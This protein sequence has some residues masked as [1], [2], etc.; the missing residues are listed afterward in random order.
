MTQEKGSAGVQP[1]FPCEVVF[2]NGAYLHTMKSLG[3]RAGL[4]CCNCQ[5]CAVREKTKK[6]GSDEFY[7][8]AGDTLLRVGTWGQP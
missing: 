6:S 4:A 5:G 8:I 1:D 7:L 2:P 3:H